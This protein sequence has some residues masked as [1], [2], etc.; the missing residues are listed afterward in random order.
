MRAR[1][2]GR[3]VLLAGG[4]SIGPGLGNGRAAAILY[5]REG[6]RVLVCDRDAAA[7]EETR[8][9]IAAEGGAAEAQAG[10]LTE[11]GAVE[12]AVARAQGWGGLDVLH[13][14]IGTSTRGGVA[15]TAPEDWDRV[16]R[17]NLRSAYLLT[18]AALPGMRARRRG[19]LIFVSSVAAIRAGPY[20]YAAYEASKAALN[21]LA[22]TVARQHAAEGIRA[23]VVM[24]GPIDTP[25]VTHVVAPGAEPEALA[26]SRA[27]MV[28]MG[29]QGTPWDVAHAAAFL[30]SD[31]ASFVTGAI[32][33]VD[34]GLSL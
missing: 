21:R 10:D 5:A 25:H 15:E 29:R 1:F 23:N 12:A 16:M 8:A 20:A 14:N 34:G 4:G 22:R 6:A 33:P 18:R 24:P 13:H 11:P 31:E 17:V 9:A 28:P 26:R 27:A 7:A 19:V 32:L 3:T 2:A 30:A